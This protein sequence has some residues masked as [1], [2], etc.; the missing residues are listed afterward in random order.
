[1]TIE[2]EGTIDPDL[3]D[4]IQKLDNIYS[5]TMLKPI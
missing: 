4:R 2:L 1:M 3:N 5:S